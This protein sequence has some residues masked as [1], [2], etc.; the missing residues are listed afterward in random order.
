MIAFV[1]VFLLQKTVLLIVKQHW[2]S[3]QGWIIALWGPRPKYFGAPLHIHHET[4]G[5]NIR[6]KS[7]V[8]QSFYFMREIRN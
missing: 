7:I 6:L 3:E 5:S 4:Q 2:C 1:Y 8:S